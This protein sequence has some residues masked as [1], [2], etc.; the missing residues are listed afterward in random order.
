MK[1]TITAET[2]QAFV[3]TLRRRTHAARRLIRCPL[4][5]LSLVL[6]N[7]ATMSDLHQSFMDDP[8][9]TDVLTFPLDA[10]ERGRTLSGEVYVCVP[11]ARRRAKQRGTHVADEVLLYALHGMLHLC[12]FDDRTPAGFAR[13]HR[14]EDRILTRIGVGPVFQPQ[15]RHAQQKTRRARASADRARSRNP[16]P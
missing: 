8:S 1:L 5:E 6:V 16:R 13:M 3:A 4:R 9:T 10:D 11:E 12:G 7:D 15:A 14:T 2:G